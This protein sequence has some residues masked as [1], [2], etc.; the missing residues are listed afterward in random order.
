MSKKMNNNNSN[1]LDVTLLQNL[2]LLNYSNIKNPYIII[3][4]II[5]MMKRNFFC[6]AVKSELLAPENESDGYPTSLY[7]S[8]VCKRTAVDWRAR[9]VSITSRQYT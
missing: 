9:L 5:I 1:D 8:S 2:T 6:E 3:T 4:H 7:D